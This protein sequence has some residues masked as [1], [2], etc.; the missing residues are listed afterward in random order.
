MPPAD[1]GNRLR[2]YAVVDLQ[3]AGDRIRALAAGGVTAVQLRE[4]KRSG[5]DAVR[6]A[7]ALA[8][9]CR[10]LGLLFI[11]ND[12][13]D[14]LAQVQAD[15]VHLGQSDGFAIARSRLSPGSVLGVSVVTP[16]QAQQALA[17]GADYLG[18]GPVFPT[19]SKP[20]AGR[21]IG[22][23]GLAAVRRAAPRIPLVAI[24]GLTPANAAAVLDAGADGLA[25]ISALLQADDPQAAAAAFSRILA[26]KRKSNV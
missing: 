26:G 6:Q 14:W 10:E 18:A 7:L 13:L 19:A 20:D 4:K 15:G 21:P 2:L 23:A 17:A 22:L 12:R 1:L 11:I 9:L 8:G 24:G 5:T 3:V 16:V 25:V